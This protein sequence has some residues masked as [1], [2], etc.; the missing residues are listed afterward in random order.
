MR[1]YYRY[2]GGEPAPGA[3][4]IRFYHSGDQIRGYIRKVADPSEDDTIFPGEEMEPEEAFRMAENKNRGPDKPPIFV[5]LSE[6][7][8]W[9]P[10]WGRLM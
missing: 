3:L 8:N 4:I 6:G 7:V 5:E 2:R 9:N 1:T 10:A